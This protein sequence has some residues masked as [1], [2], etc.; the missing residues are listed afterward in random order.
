[1]QRGPCRE[2]GRADAER[3]VGDSGARRGSE[4][5]SAER[6]AAMRGGAAGKVAASTA[7]ATTISREVELILL[8]PGNHAGKMARP[9]R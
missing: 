4:Y 5:S 6:K 9:R 7:D 8:P 3:A 2:G 1:M